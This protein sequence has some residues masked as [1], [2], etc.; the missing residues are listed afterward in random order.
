LF[1]YSACKSDNI[2]HSE[3]AGVHD[4]TPVPEHAQEAANPE[5]KGA[6]DFWRKGAKTQDKTLN[7]CR[8][9]LRCFCFAASGRK[10]QS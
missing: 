5:L 1:E 2:L 8:L 7:E 9:H 4:I 3:D 6:E 10:S